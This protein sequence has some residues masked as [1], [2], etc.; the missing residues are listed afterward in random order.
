MCKGLRL[1]HLALVF[2]F[3]LLDSGHIFTFPWHPGLLYGGIS[4]LG[5]GVVGDTGIFQRDLTLN[6]LY[7][8]VLYLPVHHLITSSESGSLHPGGKECSRRNPTCMDFVE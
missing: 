7:C 3:W 2:G 1:T 5:A 8:I 6:V 4:S